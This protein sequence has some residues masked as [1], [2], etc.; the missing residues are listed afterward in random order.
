MTLSTKLNFFYNEL[1]TVK[2]KIGNKTDKFTD[3]D[4]LN[5]KERVELLQIK[6]KIDLENI[7]DWD[8]AKKNS[9]DYELVHL[10][11]R[12]LKHESIAA[13]EPLSR[14]Y[15]KMWEILH[16]YGFFTV[17]QQKSKINIV[18]IAEGPGGFIE[19][20]VNYRYKY[21]R[22]TDEI[23]AITL[24]SVTKEIPGWDKAQSFL[25]ENPNV[26]INYG[27]DNTGNIY[28][29]ENIKHF[30]ENLAEKADFITADG[31]FDFSSD[32]ND[33]EKQSLRIIFCEIVL[34]LSCQNLG[35]T[36]ICK[37][38]DLYS[39]TSLKLIFLLKCLYN[40][41]IIDKPVTSRPAN[42]E[43]YIICKDFL[44]IDANYLSKLYIVIKSWEI[45]EEK[46]NTIID[47]FSG[48]EDIPA[49]FVES[50]LSFGT[51]HFYLQKNNIDKTLGLIHNKPNLA[52][53]N[54][55]IENQISC[56]CK[57][58]EKYNVDLNY[59]S[60]FLEKIK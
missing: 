33:Q 37:F 49:E 9:N 43:K 31:G 39:K 30:S 48:N 40:E 23:N 21:F 53:L 28:K 3:S 29:L 16:N 8:K 35:G 58:C 38:F 60:I 36:F 17:E 18:N 13:Y 56:A 1:P 57:W 26:K 2:I 50:V 5:N 32:F 25:R 55:L 54:G 34:A 41:I 19:A 45:L 22:Q 44:G 7:R 46:E 14:S 6:N 15:F 52:E 20:L 12:K 11:S 10:P 4:Y 24:K 59:Q 51:K 47:I 27:V 42:S